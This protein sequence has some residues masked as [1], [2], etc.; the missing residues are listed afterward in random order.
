MNTKSE[1]DSCRIE[2]M[3]KDISCQKYLLQ[4]M[5]E[6]G[7]A[8]R[9]SQKHV[10]EALPKILTLWFDFTAIEGREK[11]SD[12][13]HRNQD[14][15]NQLVATYVRTIPAISYYNVLPQLISRVGHNDKDTV[16]IVLA[17]LK[18]VLTKFPSQA[19]WS[20]GWL[21]HSVVSDLLFLLFSGSRF[22]AS[23]TIGCCIKC[24]FYSQINTLLTLY[25]YSFALLLMYLSKSTPTVGMTSLP[26]STFRLTVSLT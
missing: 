14:K 17:I 6:Y 3:R 18:R 15:V 5:K 22:G 13:L 9:L 4:A 7:E 23:H 25:L 2:I 12:A 24:I 8:V 11:E 16:T 19:M 26:H 20:L 10:F 1:D 21:R